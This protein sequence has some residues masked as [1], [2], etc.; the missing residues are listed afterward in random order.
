[1]TEMDISEIDEN[2]LD[3]ENTNI[4]DNNS[5]EYDEHSDSAS[6]EQI[7]YTDWNETQLDSINTTIKYH[8]D[9]IEYLTKALTQGPITEARPKE[10]KMDLAFL[11][12]EYDTIP[13]KMKK[14]TAK[15]KLNNAKKM[16]AEKLHEYLKS[17][18]IEETRS[19]NCLLNTIP[20]GGPENAIPYLKMKYL[21][22]KEKS[23]ELFEEHIKLGQDL[24]MIEARFTLEK[25]QKKLKGKWKDWIK[26]NIKMDDSYDRR[27]RNAAK[28]IDEYPELHKLNI[29]FTNFCKLMNNIKIVFMAN[30]HIGQQW[31]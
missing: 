14:L 27:H 9:M 31:K 28:F 21:K 15:E 12:K 3:S 16:T 8:K 19:S 22:L 13:D 29:E 23:N 30:P 24:K 17:I 5:L 18:K 26:D 10:S 2:I 25:K 7:V 11:E 6:V 4:N 20:D 1:M